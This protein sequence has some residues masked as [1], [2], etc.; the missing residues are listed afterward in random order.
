MFSPAPRSEGAL[1]RASRVG[2]GARCRCAVRSIRAGHGFCHPYAPGQLEAGRGHRQ[3]G[4][5]GEFSPSKKSGAHTK[6]TSVSLLFSPARGLFRWQVFNRIR[7]FLGQ[8]TK[9]SHRSLIPARSLPSALVT[10]HW[11]LGSG[12]QKLD[13]Q[14]R[15]R[16]VT[17]E[18]QRRLLKCPRTDVRIGRQDCS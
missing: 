16:Q 13:S 14:G 7:R 12:R 17:P 6:H 2:R 15:R 4:Q 5:K 10:P 1:G 18:A 9:A 11:S 3:H 8:R